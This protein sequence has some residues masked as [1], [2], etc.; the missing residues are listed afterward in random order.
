LYK[1]YYFRDRTTPTWVPRVGMTFSSPDEAWKFWV[2]YGGR[3]GFD[4]R[5]RYENRR[6]LDGKAT[7]VR[8]VCSSQGFQAKDKRDYLTSIPEPKLELDVKYAWDL[9]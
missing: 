3:T 2:T 5:K 6:K 8:F 7:S 4:V 1:C 9:H